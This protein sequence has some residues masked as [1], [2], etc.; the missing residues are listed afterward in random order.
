MEN[1]EKDF[2]SLNASTYVMFGKENE[3]LPNKRETTISWIWI[4]IELLHQR[5]AFEIYRIKITTECEK[6]KNENKQNKI[7]NFEVQ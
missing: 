5:K 7:L 2:L 1:R 3:I 4:S 6:V